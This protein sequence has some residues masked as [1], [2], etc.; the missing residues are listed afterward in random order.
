LLSEGINILASESDTRVIVPWLSGEWKCNGTLKAWG[1]AADPV[2]ILDVTAKA[3][4]ANGAL[5]FHGS[6]GEDP[7]KLGWLLEVDGG[8]GYT[9]MIA[10]PVFMKKIHCPQHAVLLAFYRGKESREMAVNVF[11]RIYDQL[12]DGAVKKAPLVLCTNP[13]VVLP[14]EMVIKIASFVGFT[15]TVLVDKKMITRRVAHIEQVSH[16]FRHIV[17]GKDFNQMWEA[18]HTSPSRLVA[19][20]ME[21]RLVR[22]SRFRLR[23]HDKRLKRHTL[24]DLIRPSHVSVE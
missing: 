13:F 15:E 23:R 4:F 6:L 24:T 3:V 7:S 20:A 5:R 9:T 19:I 14:S 17:K 8:G 21:D 1:R 22:A 16:F 10:L 18:S 11:G 2:S 12:R